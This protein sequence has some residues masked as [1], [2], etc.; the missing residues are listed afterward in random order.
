M[1]VVNELEN[2]NYTTHTSDVTTST[3]ADV[4]ECTTHHPM[5]NKPALLFNACSSMHAQG[6]FKTEQQKRS[7]IGV[8]NLMKGDN[9]GLRLVVLWHLEEFAIMGL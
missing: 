4:K 1:V 6:N 7:L 9:P 8:E 3:T 5:W 2:E